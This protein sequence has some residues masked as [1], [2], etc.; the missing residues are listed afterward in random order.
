MEA[1]VARVSARYEARVAELQDALDEEIRRR[2]EQ[3]QQQQ[4][5]Q[6]QDDED[7]THGSTTV[8][9]GV[10]FVWY[11]SCCVICVCVCV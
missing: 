8:D 5:Q 3:Q 1:A 4:Q 11:A 2:C 6:Q 9:K 7:V 10:C